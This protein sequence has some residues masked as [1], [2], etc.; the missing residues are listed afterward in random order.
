M[1]AGLKKIFLAVFGVILA[2]LGIVAG[3][4]LLAFFALY[5]L[6]EYYM[7]IPGLLFEIFVLVLGGSTTWGLVWGGLKMIKR[8]RD[9]A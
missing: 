2:L 3:L 9:K 7:C 1:K 8:T 4:Y 6:A 5:N